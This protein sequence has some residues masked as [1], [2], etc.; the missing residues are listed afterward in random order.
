GREPIHQP[1]SAAFMLSL[2]RAVVPLLRSPNVSSDRRKSPMYDLFLQS[3]PDPERFHSIRPSMLFPDPPD[4]TR[5]RGLVNKAFTAR[6]VESMRPR[7]H[8]IVRGILDEVG[9]RG[10]LDVVGDLAYPIPVTVI[11]DL[12]AIPEEDRAQVKAWSL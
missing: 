9:E 5:L 7:V 10:S 8:A 2:H 4:H 11:C 1:F 12:F 3:L 6:V